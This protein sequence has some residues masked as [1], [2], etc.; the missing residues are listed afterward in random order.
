MS[1][2]RAVMVAIIVLMTVAFG[3]ASY[4]SSEAA[5]LSGTWSLYQRANTTSFVSG[6]AG[7]ATSPGIG[8]EIVSLDAKGLAAGLSTYVYGGADL[9][10]AKGGP[11]VKIVD[12]TA[13]FTPT[14]MRVKV[15][16]G[17]PYAGCVFFLG[18]TNTG[19]TP[20]AVN[21]GGLTAEATVT[22]PVGHPNC[23]ATDFDVLAGGTNDA[24]IRAN[25]RAFDSAGVAADSKILV[26]D[27][28][29]FKQALTYTIPPGI[30]WSCPL[31]LV[32]L[33]PASENTTYT[34]VITPPTIERPPTDVLPTPTPPPPGVA[35]T[36]VPP[37]PS[38]AP[39]TGATVVAGTSVV[40]P[41]PT[42]TPIDAAAGARTPGPVT[43]PAAPGTGTGLRVQRS[44][45]TGVQLLPAI[46]ILFGLGLALFV[47]WPKR[48]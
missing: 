27:G 13:S 4:R 24:T 11:M 31:F 15:D 1:G 34:I 38:V 14:D 44:P 22:C 23:R 16:G 17:Y 46:L 28:N 48:R 7:S 2:V 30:T 32:I 37:A 42:A 19:A 47:A 21:L 43:T 12:C 18:V 36:S 39:P 20:L 25:C 26:G 45:A 6:A 9:P 10:P 35:S 40:P 33:Q 3:F 5:T 41:A 8:Y 29:I